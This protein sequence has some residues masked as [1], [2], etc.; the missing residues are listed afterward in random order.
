LAWRKSIEQK[1]K[2]DP[3][4]AIDPGAI[5]KVKTEIA[6]RRSALEVALNR[7]PAELEAIK[8]TILARRG[9]YPQHRQAYNNFVQAEIDGA[10]L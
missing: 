1:F 2:F 8:A 6:K 4:A 9:T 5:A 10:S 7:G 3:N